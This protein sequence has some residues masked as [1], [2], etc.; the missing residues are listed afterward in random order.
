LLQIVRKRLR[1]RHAF[2]RGERA[3]F[4][5]PCVYAPRQRG[6]EESRAATCEGGEKKTRKS[7]NDGLG[8]A[9]FVTGT[10]GF[11]AA[12]EVIK[13]L[14]QESAPAGSPYPWKAKRAARLA[15]SCV[16]S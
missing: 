5:I 3:R 2:P 15:E 14:S 9:V 4:G 12:G 8:S 10:L 11:A 13:M 6:P 1:Q 7:C 16:S